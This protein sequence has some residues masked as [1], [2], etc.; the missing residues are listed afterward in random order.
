MSNYLFTSES[1]SEGHPDKVADQISDAILDAILQQ[2]P[3]ARVACET[4]C[5]TG[6]IVLSGEITTDATIDYNAIP[7]GIVREIGYTSSEIGFD[8]STC[9]VLTAFNKQ[10]PD[11]AQGVNRSKDEEMDQGAGDQGLM[12]GYACDETPQLMPL[13]IYYAHRLVEQQAKLRKSGRLSW[14]RPDAKSQVSVRYEDGFPK[15]IETIVI[16]TQHSPDVPRDELVEGV[17][18]E[19]IKPVLPAEMLSNHIQYL[20]NPT[21]RFVVGG[22]MGDC[23][24]TGRKIIVDTYGGTAHHGGGAFSG[25][26]PSKVDRSAAY[27][28][29]YVAKNIVAAGLARKCEVQV[30]YAIGVAKPV[31]L[32]VQTFGTGKIPDGKLAELI[33]RHFDLRP[34]AI[35]HELDLLRPIYGKTAAYGH[36]GRE[37]PSFT[38]E[39]TDMAEQLKAD[40]GI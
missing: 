36:F 20:I 5:S 39:K 11:I 16:S 18:E 7:R 8:A 10:S 26:D 27:A 24:L 34:R 4:M 25:K 3:H 19:V 23:G 32:M 22:P 37:E 21:G 38:W 31:S 33:A 17:I 30:A 1:V 14:L 35:I 13:P 28:A 29:R 15:N 2:D 12:F 40:A 6:L 9:A